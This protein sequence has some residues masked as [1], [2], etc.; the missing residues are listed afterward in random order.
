MNN[1]HIAMKE[2]FTGNLPFKDF[3]LNAAK[4]DYSW[5]IPKTLFD[6]E[7]LNIPGSSFEANV[8]LK[9]LLNNKWHS[10]PDVRKKI[11]EWI[12]SDWGGIRSNSKNTIHKYFLHSLENTPP[13]PLTGIASFS[14]VLAIKDPLKYAIYDARVA[15]SLNA[16]QMIYNVVNG[17]AYPYLPGRNNI[18]GHW[19]SNPPRGFSR[20]DA[21][22]IETLLSAPYEWK[23]IRNKDAYSTYINLLQSISKE[24][25]APLYELEMALFSQAPELACKALPALK[26]QQ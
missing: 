3:G 25:D 24:L 2:Y 1:T 13:T 22:S 18:T 17:A 15:V 19:T 9:L 26:N 11:V 12:I 21:T 5:N 7:P 8:K 6:E 14:K 10:E 20:N 16:I 23:K 4:F